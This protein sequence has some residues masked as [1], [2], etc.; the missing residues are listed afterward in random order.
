MTGLGLVL[1]P[2][3]EHETRLSL[4]IYLYSTSNLYYMHTATVYEKYSYIF[5]Y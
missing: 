5:T 1:Y 2:D 4:L 3:L